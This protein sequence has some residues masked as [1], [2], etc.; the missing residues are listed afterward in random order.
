MKPFR[1]AAA[2]LVAFALAPQGAGAQGPD[3]RVLPRGMVE[4]RGVG[5]FRA[6]QDRLGG[7]RTP[8]GSRLEALLAPRADSLVGPDVAALRPRLA[9]FFA[10]TGGGGPADPLTAG[11]VSALLAGD[12]RDVPI[13]LAVGLTRRITLEAVVPVV[14]RGTAVRG[15]FLEGGNVGANPNAQL[16]AAILG[17]VDTAFAALGRSALLPVAGTAAAEALRDR[18]EARLTKGAADSLALP[19]RG[20]ALNELLADQGRASRLSA[21]ERA[22]LAQRGGRTPFQLGDVELGARVRLAGDAPAWGLPDD[23]AALRGFRAVAGARVRLPTGPRNHAL[24]LLQEPSRTGVFGVGGDAVA[25]WFLSSRWW[26]TADA[27]AHLFGAASVQ[28]LAFTEALPFPDTTQR[29]TLRRE[30]GLLFGAGVTPHYR[31]TREL[32]FAAQYRFE[33]AG[34]V[35]YS[36]EG[37][38]VLGPIE[39]VAAQT[40]HRIGVGAGYSTVGAFAAG[41]APFPADVSLLYA[42]TVA[43]SGGAPADVRLELQ[44]R[45]YYPA[46]GRARRARP[47]SIPAPAPPDTTR[48]RPGAV[49][50]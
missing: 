22:A 43:G 49:P 20:I 17:R 2:L 48:Q 10:A 38:G 37:A 27:E 14:R 16:N 23:S 30:Q 40:A 18:V 24:F 32:S 9:S 11:T 34:G 47:D 4:V 29:R 39:N 1:T 45:A 31:L 8:L 21:A 25:E 35:T 5:I 41:R 6:Y 33:S 19:T 44:V 28:R 26:V 46:F 42:R 12:A 15:I 50:D 13:G 7:G 36:G 3:A